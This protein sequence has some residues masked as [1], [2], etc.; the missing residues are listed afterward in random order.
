MTI[1]NVKE[2][3]KKDA[4]ASLD[5]EAKKKSTKNKKE[6]KMPDKKDSKKQDIK[7]SNNEKSAVAEDIKAAEKKKPE[8]TGLAPGVTLAPQNENQADLGLVSN[9]VEVSCVSVPV[10]DDEG[11]YIDDTDDYKLVQD[12]IA[13]NKGKKESDIKDTELLKSGTQL[14]VDFDAK[15][16]LQAV[17]SLGM[18]NKY[19]LILGMILNI[20]KDSFEAINTDDKNASWM[21]Y[22]ASCKFKFSLSSA[23]KYMKLAKIQNVMR[24]AFLGLERLEAIYTVIKKTVYIKMEDPIGEFFRD[25]DIA[26]EFHKEDLNN[27]GN[28][29]NFAVV[30]KK[31]KMHFET[32]NKDLPESKQVE[33]TVDR[34]LVK[35]LINGGIECKAGTIADL[36]LFA[37]G[38]ADPSV[39]L[40]EL[41]MNGGNK[42]SKSVKGNLTELKAL[43][44][45]LKITSQ[46]QSK[47]NVLKSNSTLLAKVKPEHIEALQ[48]QVTALANLV[49]VKSTTK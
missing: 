18:L 12:F 8:E 19:R 24:W 22:Y 33:D 37:K 2:K 43:E 7:T 4:D 47:V 49:N 15:V 3:N 1:S 42:H 36:F 10:D 13:T 6:A 39:I 35:E 16:G 31:I 32:K 28:A 23:E 48:E 21:R 46:L 26:I 30:D 44:G 11:Q 29:I 14:A 5:A 20:L 45:F 9:G 40:S 38:G 17:I 41:L 27:W 34:S 25:S